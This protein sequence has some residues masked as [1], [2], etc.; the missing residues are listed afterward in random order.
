[1]SREEWKQIPG[2]DGYMVSN[3]GEVL[4]TVKQ[5][6]S[7]KE[8]HVVPFY[9]RKLLAQHKNKGGYMCVGIGGKYQGGRKTVKVHRLVASAFVKNPDNLPEVNHIDGDKTNNSAD[10]LEWTT[11]SENEK[12]A[13]RTGLQPRTQK[14]LDLFRNNRTDNSIK[15]IAVSKCGEKRYFKSIQ[16]CADF[17]GVDRSCVS[18]ACNKGRKTNGYL[19]FYDRQCPRVEIE[20][21]EMED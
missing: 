1:M 9:R 6:Y 19:I 5:V 2:Y 3:T 16:E 11:H 18:R 17:I 13:Y 20:I 21:T 14:R 10:N 15:V 12:H 4:S 8:K 7:K